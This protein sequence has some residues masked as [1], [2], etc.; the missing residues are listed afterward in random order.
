M[1]NQEED[2]WDTDELFGWLNSSGEAYNAARSVALIYGAR[3]LKEYVKSHDL[4]YY[5]NKQCAPN[6]QID[7]NNIDWDQLAEDLISE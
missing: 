1:S 2:S 3:S 5:F 4:I 7:P 6:A